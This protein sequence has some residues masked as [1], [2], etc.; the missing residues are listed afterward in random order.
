MLLSSTAVKICKT[1]ITKHFM[2]LNFFY[3]LTSSLV[4]VEN[5]FAI[6]QSK[7]DHIYGEH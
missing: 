1:E 4:P 6:R 5:R 2:A 3:L 7:P